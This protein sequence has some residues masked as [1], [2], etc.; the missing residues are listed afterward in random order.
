VASKSTCDRKRCA[1]AAEG[2]E[3]CAA[4]DAFKAIGR[5]VVLLLL[6][7]ASAPMR[8]RLAA[9]IGWALGAGA[10]GK[11][12]DTA[13]QTERMSSSLSAPAL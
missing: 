6:L 13:Q 7:A 4:T 5:A 11:G 9:C 2:A 12:A 8:A 3:A 10:A 1:G